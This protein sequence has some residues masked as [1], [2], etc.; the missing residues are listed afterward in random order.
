MSR[1]FQ[2][3]VLFALVLSSGKPCR[4]LAKTP[5]Q[6][7]LVNAGERAYRAFRDGKLNVVF[8]MLSE[9]GVIV[10]FRSVDWTKFRKHARGVLAD[11]E[12]NYTLDDLAPFVW[13]EGKLNSTVRIR[14]RPQN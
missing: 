13:I 8:S 1:R 6:V 4:L 14:M 3:I 9:N 2:Q 12:R 7:N 5:S 10:A 11:D